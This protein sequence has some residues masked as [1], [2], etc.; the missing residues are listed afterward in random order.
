MGILDDK[1]LKKRQ[2]KDIVEEICTRFNKDGIKR[3]K[4][5][6]HFEKYTPLYHFCIAEDLGNDFIFITDLFG[7]VGIKP[8]LMNY[9]V[10]K[11]YHGNYKG[12]SG[13]ILQGINPGMARPCYRV[14]AKKD[15]ITQED[16]LKFDKALQYIQHALE[17]ITPETR[18]FNVHN[19]VFSETFNLLD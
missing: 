5:V 4:I 6:G 16:K 1:L 3:L 18:R 13:I 11:Q 15:S 14:D 8:G 7:D 9:G 2:R 17:L 19:E 10:R 12:L